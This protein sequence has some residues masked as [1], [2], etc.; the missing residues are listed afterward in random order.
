MLNKDT[1]RTLTDKWNPILEGIQDSSTRESTA[2]LLENQARSIMNEMAKDGNSLN[3]SGTSV[4]HLGTFQK[5]A[6]PLIR[7]VFP[8]LIAN[9]V[10]GVQPMQA[11]VSQV[12]YLG[13][14]RTGNNNAG[15]ARTQTVYSR[16]NL[17]Y[18]GND[19]AANA[20]NGWGAT[21]SLDDQVN[22]G[23]P[24]DGAI[25]S[26]ANLGLSSHTTHANDTVGGQIAAFPNETKTCV[27][28]LGFGKRTH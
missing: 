4:G 28:Q 8:E 12:F 6:F 24:Y 2:V 13:Y 10:C 17:T 9:K 15:T 16:Y 27:P 11:P 14:S 19:A 21:S 22:A 20:A 23:G 18:R 3:E 1:S 25:D 7:R 5:F 26:G